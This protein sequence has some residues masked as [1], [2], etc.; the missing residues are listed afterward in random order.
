MIHKKRFF[1]TL[2]SPKR[3][4]GMLATVSSL[5][6]RASRLFAVAVLAALFASAVVPIQAQ[7]YFRHDSGLAS[8]DEQ[9]LPER[10]DPAHADWKQT[11][12]PGH[13]TPCVVGDR[14]FVT[15]HE[16]SELETICLDRASGV[17]Q[18]KQGIQAEQLEKFHTEGSP[19]AAT[20]AC[21]GKRVYSFFGSFGL[22][23]YDVD[24]KPL[25]SKKL[26]P[27]RDE[28]GSASSPI[29]VDDMVV[30]AEDHDL[31]SFLIAVRADS[32]ETVWQTARE[33]FTRSYS[34]P[35]VWEAGGKR[36]IVVAGA[37]QLVGYDIATGRAQWALD[38]FARIVN[39][40][41]AKVDGTLFVCTWSPGG[42]SDA[43]I[44]ME[45]WDTALQLWDKNKN[46]KL[47]D[48][49]LPAGEVRSRFFRIDLDGDQALDQAEW[50][51]Y[52]RIFELAQNTLVALRPGPDGQAPRVIW[53]YKRGLPYV[54][55][56][57]VYRGRLF[58]VK[59]GGVATL[60]EAANGKLL[61]QGRVRG[62]GNYYSSPVGG[63]GKIY[64]A[65]GGGMVSVLKAGDR[66]EP[67]ASDDFG[68]RIAATPVIL[69]GHIY[70]R[71]EKALYC[72][73]KR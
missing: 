18:W 26:G 44:A 40:T 38:G 71:T 72:F 8:N 65:S 31:D 42:D 62:E 9:P 54:S 70:L 67:I 66:V 56:P 36:Q 58:L 30:L 24:G 69:D 48:V 35:V 53:Q 61:K 37:L 12:P 2:T 1:P 15:A 46:G 14:I 22:L 5:A 68:E 57:L 59:D 41:P 47:E 64:I 23:C 27:F 43:R 32:G 73:S 13:S 29:L 51:K 10:L 6:L 11:L 3:E 20:P 63:D 55:S 34:T 4:R 50:S 19:A 39:T 45:P 21:D 25:W 49:E 16:G 17:V 60:L 52:A 7:V 33:G 28:F